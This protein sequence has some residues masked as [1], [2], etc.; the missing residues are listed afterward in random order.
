MRQLIVFFSLVL[1]ATA[2][3]QAPAQQG[4]ERKPLS[5]SEL[6]REHYFRQEQANLV[7][8]EESRRILAELAAM[9]AELQELRRLCR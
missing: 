5:D 7:Q 9:R 4:G 3:A 1:A 2:H 8:R 6:L